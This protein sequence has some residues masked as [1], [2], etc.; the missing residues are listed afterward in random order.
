MSDANKQFLQP[1]T[2]LEQETEQAAQ[3]RDME[4]SIERAKTETRLESNRRSAKNN[5]LRQK[6]LIDS[7]QAEN[8]FLRTELTKALNRIDQ[9]KLTLH[10]ETERALEYNRCL[11][12]MVENNMMKQQQSREDLHRTSCT[13]ASTLSM[14]SQQDEQTANGVAVRSSSLGPATYPSRDAGNYGHDAGSGSNIPSCYS[15]VGRTSNS[16]SMIVTDLEQLDRLRRE[17]EILKG[18]VN[19]LKR[20][21][22]W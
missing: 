19:S 11:Q 3:T 13:N 1:R 9:L 2:P 14:R 5:R 21:W 15:S 17:V 8:Q 6:N 4:R 12:L 10:Q 22:D 16:D 18:S 20:S 7:L